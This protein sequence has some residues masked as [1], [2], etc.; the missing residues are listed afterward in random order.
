[1]ILTDILSSVITTVFLLFLLSYYALFFIK[2]RLSR[3]DK[4]YK[5]ISVIIPAHNEEEF[6]EEAIESVLKARFVGNKEVLVVNDGSSDRTLELIKKYKDKV[7]IIDNKK[8]SGKSFSLNRALAKAK[9]D[10]IAIVDGDSYIMRDALVRSIREVS[11]KDVVATC[12]V[13]KVRNRYRLIGMWLHIELVYNSLIRSLFGKINANVVTPGALSVYRRKELIDIGG[14]STEG[15]SEDVDIAIRL[16]RKGYKITFN[17][18]IVS[19]TNMPYDPKGFL[20]QRTRLARGL[21]NLLKRHMKMN[22]TIID[23]YTLPLFLFT[24][25]QAVI[26]GGLTIYNMTSGYI[27]YYL[28]KGVYFSFDVVRFFFEWLSIFGFMNWTYDV[29]VGNAAFNFLSAV[30]I[31]STFLSYPL[32]F[33]AIIKYDKKFDIRHLIPIFFMAPYWL[34][35]MVI[36]TICIPELLAKKQYNIWKKNE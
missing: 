11:R 32:F 18:K 34:L 21:I 16:I 23:I 36:Y 9:G 17:D 10:V 8:H 31:F 25:I 27:L 12:G 26:M 35:I 14:F 7:K 15:F 24:Y 29:I 20:R 5:S 3:L 1:M 13:V 30:G 28:S 33:Y 19:E 2:R 22:K 6:I 4:K